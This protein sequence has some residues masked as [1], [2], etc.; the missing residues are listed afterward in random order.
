MKNKTS[1]RIGWAW[2]Y[3]GGAIVSP[4]F[5]DREAL[6]REYP[7]PDAKRRAF[8]SVSFVVKVRVVSLREYA[9][10]K[11][12]AESWKQHLVDLADAGES[13]PC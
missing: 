10:D 3:R 12:D 8:R 6:L 2:K 5:L 1:A 9:K 4:I 7:G 13:Q 11:R